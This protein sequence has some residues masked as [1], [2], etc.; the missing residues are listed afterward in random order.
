MPHMIYIMSPNKNFVNFALRNF[1]SFSL[2]RISRFW[3]VDENISLLLSFSKKTCFQNWF[4]QGLI[5]T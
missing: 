4:P 3:I 1:T 2:R 5:C